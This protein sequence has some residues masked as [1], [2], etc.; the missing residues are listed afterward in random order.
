[1]KKLTILTALVIIVAG[2]ITI[3]NLIPPKTSI[4]KATK[5]CVV[6]GASSGIGLEISKEMIK[7][8]WKVIGI[9]RRWNLLN[10][11]KKDLGGKSFIPYMCDVDDPDQ[12]YII[13]EE[14]KYQGHKPTLFFLNAGTGF[15]ENKW[16]ISTE[17]H[18]KIFDT[19][20][21][22]VLT[23]IEQWLKPIRKLGGGTFVVTSSLISLFAMPES[24]SYFASKAAINS[25]FQSFRRQYYN[26]NIGFSVV[27]PGPVETDM[28]KGNLRKLPFKQKPE[29]T[30]KYI[31]DKVLLGKEQIEPSWFYS[32]VVRVA[33]L[34]PEFKIQKILKS[35]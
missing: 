10:K 2:Y 35:K 15:P 20:Y 17:L 14:I 21:F 7:K 1:M 13:S 19:N 31:V 23:W 4:N 33:N 6:T 22:G 26:D 32:I 27:L 9:A 12:V 25:C 28:L 29:T 30:A 18:R 3:S 11:H 24:A 34:L 5:T 8:G 16:E